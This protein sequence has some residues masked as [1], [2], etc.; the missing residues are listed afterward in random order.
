MWGLNNVGQLGDGSPNSVPNTKP[1]EVGHISDKTFV[2][3]WANITKDGT[4]ITGGKYDKFNPL[5]SHVYIAAD[6]KLEINKSKRRFSSGLICFKIRRTTTLIL[7]RLS[8]S[9]RI[10][11]LQ[12]SMKMV[13]LHLMQTADME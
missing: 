8:L 7:Q 3:D 9:A 1:V 6:Q 4:P 5:P 10:R 13:W 11:A 12:R 2:T